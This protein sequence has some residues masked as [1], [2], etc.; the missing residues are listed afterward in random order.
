MI[1]LV[2]LTLFLL[3]AC[4]EAPPAQEFNA[5]DRAWIQLMIPMNEQMLPLLELAR[6]R[7]ADPR[8]KQ[9]ADQIRG[10]HLTELEA[11]RHLRDLA[12]IP[13]GNVHA[14]HV[15]PGLIA[16]AELDSIGAAAGVGFDQLYAASLRVHLQQTEQLARS[17]QQAGAHSGCKAVAGSIVEARQRQ[18]GELSKER[19]PS[20]LYLGLNDI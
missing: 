9:Q 18:L 6:D 12:G 4:T 3:T 8:L 17:Q 10:S 20:A 5:T 19:S 1:R 11:L 16:T 7:A 2:I 13:A 14:G 15:M